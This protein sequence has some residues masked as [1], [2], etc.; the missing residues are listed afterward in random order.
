MGSIRLGIVSGETGEIL[1]IGA[2]VDLKEIPGA[3]SRFDD[4]QLAFLPDCPA[5]TRAFERLLLL[6]SDRQ[7]RKSQSS[8]RAN[9]LVRP[10]KTRYRTRPE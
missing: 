6:A 4:L 3:V 1:A 5:L 8:R 10:E 9:G 7:P 2:N